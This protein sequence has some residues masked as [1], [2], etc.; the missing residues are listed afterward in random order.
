MA[1]KSAP[2]QTPPPVPAP[3]P[4]VRLLLIDDQ[5]LFRRGLTTILAQNARF[6]VVGEA[7][8][9]EE[10]ERRAS[11]LK[12]DVILLESRLPDLNGAHALKRLRQASPSTRVLVLTS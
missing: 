2:A 7:A 4:P 11:E 10:G 5:A 6:A 1:P 8:T 12:P 9:A 3:P